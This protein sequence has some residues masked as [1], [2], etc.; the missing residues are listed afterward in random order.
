MVATAATRPREHAVVVGASMAGLAAAAALAPH[1]DRVTVL[2]RDALPA[3]PAT[4]RAVPQGR[5]AHGFQP[6]GLEAL[7]ELLP[8]LTEEL[9]AG[10]A[11][12]GDIGEQMSWFIGGGTLAKAPT[13][14]RAVGVSRPYLEH[15]V[16]RRVTSLPHVK[17]RD[18]CEAISPLRAA[19]RSVTGLQ[20]ISGERPETDEMT[21]DLVVD[22]SGRGSRLPQWLA[23]LGLPAPS[24]ERVHCKIAYLSRRWHFPNDIMGEDICQV[25][26]PADTPHFGVCIAQED[27][28]HIVTLGGLL[29]AAPARTDEAYREFARSLP[30][31]RI[32]DVLQDAEPVGDLQASHFPYSRRRRYDTLSE[33]PI[34]LVALGDSIASFNP[35]YGQGMTV[36]AL[37]AVELRDQLNKGAL[38]PKT[39]YRAA[40]R[41]EDVAWRISASSDLR[42][43]EVKGHRTT[44]MRIMNAYLDRLTRTARQDPALAAQFLRVS[45]FVDPPASLFSPRIVARVA[46][47]A[48]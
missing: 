16:R 22:T 30:D 9:V 23:E 15:V 41:L 48:R 35:M 11:R 12:P 26:A 3:E 2:D 24:E 36:A 1:F 25:V 10:G 47:R 28:A 46:H 33:H 8:G 7:E 29:D 18:G 21:A 45:G 19:G 5:H 4:R 39:F 6:G 31:P 44:G 20:L 13:G 14:S 40:H 17:I 42:F 32:G 34:G 27:G 37:Q 38:D 43:P